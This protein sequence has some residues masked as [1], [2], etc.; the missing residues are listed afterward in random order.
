MQPLAI[1][2]QHP[3]GSTE[4]SSNGSDRVV[5]MENSL[6]EAE[7]VLLRETKKAQMADLDED[8]LIALHS[9]VRRARKKYVTLYR[10]AGA[11][12]VKQ[13]GGRGS[14]KSAN[15][16]NAAK[17]EVFEDALSRVSRQLAVVS[18]QSARKLKDERLALARNDA[19]SFPGS[20][21]SDRTAHRA[22]SKRAKVGRKSGGR[23]KFEASTLAAGARRQAKKDHR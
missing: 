6:S 5:K 10:R 2:W 1:I 15:T 7:F 8:E 14:G 11:T 21:D 19:P 9:R 16:R 18:R 3:F 23:K 20:G 22:D 13:K 4:D 17:A 12:K